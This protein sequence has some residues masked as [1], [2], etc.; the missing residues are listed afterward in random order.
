[1]TPAPR[2]L[3]ESPSGPSPANTNNDNTATNTHTAVKQP[4]LPAPRTSRASTHPQWTRKIPL[5]PT[6]PASARQFNNRNHYRQFI[7]RPSPRYNIN[8]TFSGPST[9]NNYRFHQLPHI[10]GPC[11]QSFT[12]RPY[13]QPQGHQ[14]PALLPLPSHKI[15]AFSGPLQHAQG[16]TTQQV[17][18]YLPVFLQYPNHLISFLLYMYA[19]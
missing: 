1:M 8:S 18:T 17:L 6:P 4:T 9:L 5:L 15:P 7:P 16:H 13:P 2:T 12:P 14:Q 10:P 11:Q 19:V 3:N